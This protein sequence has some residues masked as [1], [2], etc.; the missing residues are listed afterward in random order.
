M[1]YY[2]MTYTY[3]HQLYVWGR[4]G[5]MHPLEWMATEN[6]TRKNVNEPAIY[7]NSFFEITREQYEMLETVL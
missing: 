7:I 4:V 1:K 3:K 5:M 2:Y 6:K